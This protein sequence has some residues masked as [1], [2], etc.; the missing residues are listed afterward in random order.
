MQGLI[1]IFFTG[2]YISLLTIKHRFSSSPWPTLIL[3]VPQI[4]LVIILPLLLK[5]IYR[6]RIRRSIRRVTDPGKL[7][8]D[9][10]SRRIRKAGCSRVAD[11]SIFG[12]IRIQQ[13]RILKTRSGS[14]SYC[15]WPRINSNI[16]IFISHQSDFFWYLNDDYFYLKKWKNSP[17]NV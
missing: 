3:I 15:H 14:G 6:I 12:R 17:E 16:K 5:K 11:P 9:F 10:R 13:I 7:Y 4:S 2:T 1:E 8:V